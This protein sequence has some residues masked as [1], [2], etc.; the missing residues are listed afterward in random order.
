L[1]NKSYEIHHYLQVKG[2]A[3]HHYDHSGNSLDEIITRVR[4][5]GSTSNPESWYTRYDHHDNTLLI[6]SMTI[7]MTCDAVDSGCYLPIP[8]F[9]NDAATQVDEQL[10]Q[11]HCYRPR[12]Q[13]WA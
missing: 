8:Y 4:Y 12:L 3:W 1:N 7:I 2:S 11:L 5:T 9:E 13:Q 10:M 6:D